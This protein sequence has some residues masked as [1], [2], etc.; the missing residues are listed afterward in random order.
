MI[1]LNK[2]LAER[3]GISRREADNYIVAGRVKVDGKEA[4]LGDRIENE[5]VVVFDGK[6]IPLE[7]HYTYLILNKPAGY[8]CSKR[9]QGAT[10]TLFELLPKKYQ[11]LKTV[12]RLD[13][14]SSGLILLTNDGDLAF[15]MTHPS[16]YKIKTYLVELD[17]PIEPLYR[18]MISDFG[19]NLSDGLSKFFITKLPTNNQN[20]LK[21]GQF[22]RVEMSEGRNRQIRRTFAALGYEVTKLHRIEFGNY[23]L[24][25]LQSG[26]FIETTR[27]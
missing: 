9:R 3:I 7:N 14:N 5:Q 16:F 20:M 23:T 1:R 12:G 6:K 19:V 8:V 11:H 2:F 21:D 10:P 25:D 13:K 17:R 15:K 24:N 22:L 27:K 18:Q 4:I 26:K